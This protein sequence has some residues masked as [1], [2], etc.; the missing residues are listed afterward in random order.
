[1][2]YEVIW[3]RTALDDYQGI[4]SFLENERSEPAAKRFA[5]EVLKMTGRLSTMPYIGVLSEKNP[6]VRR[7]LISPEVSLY[8]SVQPPL[9]FSA[10]FS[11]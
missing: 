8:Y 10:Q 9:V 2:A 4:S 11:G 5:R 6:V 7:V 1:M 3:T